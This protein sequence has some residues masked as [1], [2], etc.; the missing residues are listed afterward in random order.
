MKNQLEY[1]LSNFQLYYHVEKIDIGY[2]SAGKNKVIIKKSPD[3]EFFE[4]LNDI[5]PEKVIWK[6]WK[7][8]NIPFCFDDNENDDIISTKDDQI[9][10]NFDIVAS[11]FYFLSGWNEYVN[12]KKDEFGRISYKYSIINKLE[13]SLIPVV[14]YYFDILNDAIKRAGEVVEK[15]NLWNKNDFGI[16]L[17]HDI[18]V[19]KSAWLEG[20]NIALRKGNFFQISK[21]VY[22]RFFKK[23]A[24]FNFKEIQNIEKENNGVSSF[25]F[26]PQQGKV[27]KWKNADY[28][29]N[30]KD[31]RESI[32]YLID[33]GNEIGIH[34]SFG[35]HSS[36]KKFK[37]DKDKLKLSIIGNRFHF[38]M[39]DP[40]LT[41]SVLEKNE[42]KY[43]TTLGFAEQIGFRRGTCFPF[44]LYNFEEKR[45]SSIVEVP[46][47]T[48]DSTLY[49]S[50]YMGLT[51]E[52]S[53]F[54]VKSLINEIKKFNGVFTLLWHNTFFSE[55]KYTGWKE[56][57]VQILKYCNQQNGLLTTSGNIYKAIKQKE[58]YE[59]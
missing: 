14:N 59:A 38:L 2:G 13:I 35:T 11:T 24:W 3:N 42:M 15:K 4:S 18:D 57:Y 31:I 36:S 43:D 20:S 46:L 23:D 7:G 47:I 10:I 30:S 55:Y 52:E 49:N 39:F 33:G 5:D 21:L 26:L 27:G 34:G 58:H 9:L 48:M 12:S 1:F 41:V 25:Y 16:A 40:K 54:Q 28:S 6:E 22:K 19:C 8:V 51:K 45:I 50:K 44:Y 53:V 37:I 56:V 29:I 17:T 32:K